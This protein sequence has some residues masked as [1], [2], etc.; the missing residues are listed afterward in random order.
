MYIL[1]KPTRTNA[2]FFIMALLCSC[3]LKQMMDVVM[4]LWLFVKRAAKQAA[5]HNS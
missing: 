5:K 1:N 2:F 3:M 4:L